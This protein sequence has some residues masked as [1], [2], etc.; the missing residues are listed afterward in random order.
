MVTIRVERLDAA[1]HPHD[2]ARSKEIA[3]SALAVQLVT[4]EAS[5]DINR[6]TPG[7]RTPDCDWWSAHGTVRT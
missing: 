5:G 7:L 1:Q 2:L 3:P 6:H 4:A